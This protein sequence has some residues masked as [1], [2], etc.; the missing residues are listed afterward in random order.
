MDTE[1][2][3]RAEAEANLCRTFNNTRRV[4][5]LW[6]LGDQEMSV[7]EIAA[8]IG[9]TVPNTSQHLQ[10]MKDRGVLVSRREGQTIYY[11]VADL[12]ILTKFGASAVH[13]P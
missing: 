10:V 4:L 6:T 3:Q 13:L 12:S 5:I 8:A 11:R 1:L 7:S 2:L 9:A